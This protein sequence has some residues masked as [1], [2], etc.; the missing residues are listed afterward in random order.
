MMTANSESD[1]T[2]MTNSV[3]SIATSKIDVFMNANTKTHSVNQETSAGIISYNGGD[4][5]IWAKYNRVGTGYD[6]PALVW[7]NYH[8]KGKTTLYSTSR[9]TVYTPSEKDAKKSE[10]ES[11]VRK[12]IDSGT[13]TSL[14]IVDDVLDRTEKVITSTQALEFTT[15]A[16]ATNAELWP[17]GSNLKSVVSPITG[18]P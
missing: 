17:S 6:Y 10:L 11:A 9:Y 13:T 5:E 3:K 18:L 8:L 1:L 14:M 15:T 4:Y 12:A 7:I 2:S 16:Q